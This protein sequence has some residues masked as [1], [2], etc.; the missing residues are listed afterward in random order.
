MLTATLTGDGETYMASLKSGLKKQ[1]M[2]SFKLVQ[3][4]W[5]LQQLCEFSTD[6]P[7][8]A[9][10]AYNMVAYGYANGEILEK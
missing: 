7:E 3:F 6:F 8:H 5:R 9:S 2:P 1:N 4:R 10:A